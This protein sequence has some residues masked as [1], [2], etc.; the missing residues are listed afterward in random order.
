VNGANDF[1]PVSSG[2][3]GGNPI[4]L[5]P[6][7][8]ATNADGTFYIGLGKQNIFASEFGASVYSSFESMAPTIAKEHWSI[9][10]GTPP[11]T[12]GGKFAKA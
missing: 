6:N 10:G 9:H 2:M 3:N 11:D 12:C 1:E 7:S 8:N 4:E 5:S